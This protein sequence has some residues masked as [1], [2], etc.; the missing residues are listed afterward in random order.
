MA[1]LIIT[2]FVM[3]GAW[4]M[5]QKMGR[6]GWE[7]IIPF[8]NL[9]VLFQAIYGRGWRFLLFLVPIYNIYL[10]FR[11]GID[12]AQSF[13][14]GVGYG[15]GLTLLPVV[16]VPLTGFGSAVFGD[17]SKAA[18]GDDPISRTLDEVS[19]RI[20]GEGGSGERQEEKRQQEVLRM[21]REL[22]TLRNAG[23][24]TD[25]E[26]EEKKAAILKKL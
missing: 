18:T 26:F 13:H 19:S 9:Y 6:Q 12:L 22:E 20:N 16:F 2:L 3:A 4:R 23:V 24:L 21:L 15:I 11:V 1:E 17:G 14:Q 10:A 25:E 5:F 7:A 8:Y